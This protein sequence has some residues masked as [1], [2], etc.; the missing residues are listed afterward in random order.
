[1]DAF[2]QD[3]RYAART[4]RK[5]PTFTIIAIVCLAVGIATNTTLF[6]CFNAIVLRPCMSA[7]DPVSFIGVTV[8]LAAIAF[9]ASLI[10]A[11]RTTAVD[12][13]VALRND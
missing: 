4:L 12:P 1:M 7:A 3:V 10:P 9:L 2:L 13:L 11:R 8:F 5:N 6:S